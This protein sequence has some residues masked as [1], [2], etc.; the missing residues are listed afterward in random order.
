MERDDLIINDSYSLNATHSEEQ[1]RQIRKKILKVTLILTVITIAEVFLGIYIKHDSSI[2]PILKWIFIILTLFKAGYIVAVFM[3]LAD[4]TKALRYMILVP[5]AIFAIYLIFVS[6]T[7]SNF[8][9]DMW[10]I[11]AP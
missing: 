8:I 5:Y 7:E 1:G 11:Y 4:E 3:H 10:H 9:N 6:I 2:W